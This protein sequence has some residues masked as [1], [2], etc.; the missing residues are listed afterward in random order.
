MS[1][2]WPRDDWPVV[3]RVPGFAG[4]GRCR[5]DGTRNGV[6][7]AARGGQLAGLNRVAE[8]CRVSGCVGEGTRNRVC[9]SWAWSGNGG[10]GE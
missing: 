6:C 7:L 8:F 2:C 4:V 10:G 5:G 1:E 9:R 3:G